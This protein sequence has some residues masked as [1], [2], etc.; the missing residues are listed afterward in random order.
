MLD[1]CMNSSFQESIHYSQRGLTLIEVL[2]SVVILSVGLLAVATMISRSTIQDS[3]AYYATHA[4]MFAEELL[5]NATKSQYDVNQYKNMTSGN[6]SRMIDGVEY[7]MICVLTDD[8]PMNKCKEMRCSVNW[9]NK[10]QQSSSQ[11]V[12]VFSPKY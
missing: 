5:E 8:T 10:G 3:R 11:Y 2:V 9:N 4:N 7:T 1:K 12:Y 6:F